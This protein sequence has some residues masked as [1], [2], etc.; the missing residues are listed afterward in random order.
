MI[1]KSHKI[2]IFLFFYLICFK[3][4][5]QEQFNFDVTEI[6]ISENGNKFIGT[7]R[8]KIT[9]GDGVIIEANEFE[10]IKNLNLLKADGN[11]KII[12]KSNNNLIYTDNLIYEKQNEIIYT[13][14]NSKALDLVKK[15]ELTASN[16]IYDRAKNIIEAEK[17]VFI[18]DKLNDYKIYTEFMSYKINEEK[19]FTKGITSGLIQSKYD[20]KSEDMVLLRDAQNLSS[21][22][23][24]TIKDNSNLYSVQNFNYSIIDERLGGENFLITSNYKKPNADKFFF[25]NAIVN[26]KNQNF[27]AKD[28]KITLHK[29]I[30]NDTDNDP[31]LLGVSSRKEGNITTVNKGIFTSCKKKDNCPPW[32]IQAKEIIHDKQKKQLLYNNAVLKIYDVPVLYFP[33]FFHP[34]PTVKRQSGFLQP[35]FNKSNILGNSLSVPY[36]HV[37]SVDKD[38]TINPTIIDSG[39]TSFQGEYRQENY[40]SSFIADFGIVNKFKSKY[41]SRKKNITHL[42]AKS[43]IDLNFE[44]FSD[45]NL[46]FYL[47]KTNKDTYLKIFDIYLLENEIK[48]KDNNVLSSGIDL[49]LKNEKYNLNTGFSA[50]E[51]LSKQQSDRYQFILPYFNFNTVLDNDFGRIDFFSNGNNILQNTNNLKTRVVNDINFSSV[52]YLN[53]NTGFKSNI[54]LF[55]KNVNTVA[56]ND[57]VYK[58]SP[59]SELMNILEF[60]T[61]YPLIKQ[62]DEGSKLLT[63]KL[64]LRINPGDMKN[65][66]ST[67]RVINADN[68]FSIN[69]LG[70]EDSLESGKSLTLGIDYS[71][72]NLIKNNEINANIATVLRDELEDSIPEKT[73]L[74]KK[75]SYLFG[76]VDFR[77]E[78][79]LNLDY[80][81]AYDNDTS[82]MK[83]HDL[84][85]NFSVNNFV[86]NF[87]FIEEDGAI[88]TTHVIENKSTLKFNKNNFISFKTRRNK[89]I[90]LTEYYDLI[91]EYKNDCLIAG[92]KFKKTFYQDRDIEPSEDLF[93]YITLIPLTTFE[94]GIDDR[95]YK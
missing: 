80:N 66:S 94:Q 7:K 50:Y 37:I 12:D 31:R 52:D 85:I 70:L 34:D 63:P 22:K 75:N 48:P 13:K 65:H 62:T 41:S 26:L 47:E 4:F 72:N 90:N 73:T 76:S 68:I 87:N 28:T 55:F 78:E 42:F 57:T 14:N 43:D 36:Y 88:G 60:N 8:G 30:F 32:A 69:R 89:E 91:Y 79:I 71:N 24:I 6:Q 67:D 25:S 40:K 84:G 3:A 33:K 38:F 44:N 58:S 2:L 9:T 61:T 81:F 27:I 5:G 83:Y 82:S 77:K 54:N 95:L 29:D 74:N 11:I 39:T 21:K 23:K 46:K 35:I 18:E 93:F 64:S 92:L 49:Y 17:N 59:Q 86:T 45:S 16:F 10:Y 53:S 15:I 1:N 56:K 20:F 51:N 19:I